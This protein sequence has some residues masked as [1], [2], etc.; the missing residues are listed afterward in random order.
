MEGY[1]K[2]GVTLSK[3][4]YAVQIA[5]YQ[6]YMELTETPCLFT[7]VNKNTSEIYYEIIP[8]NQGLAQE[9]SDRAVNILTAAKA[10]DILPRIAQSKDFFLCKFCEYRDSC[11]GE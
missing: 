9:A 10:N 3:P 2:R 8:F 6:A 1:V 4:V 7:V 11:W 5:L